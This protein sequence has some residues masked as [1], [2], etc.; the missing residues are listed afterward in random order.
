MYWRRL[1]EGLHTLFD[2]TEEAVQGALSNAASQSLESAYRT[3][4]AH[5]QTLQVHGYP[6]GFRFCNRSPDLPHLYEC[7]GSDGIE[8]IGLGFSSDSQEMA[9]IKS[10]SESLERYLWREKK[11]FEG[12]HVRTTRYDKL[13]GALNP[14]HLAGFSESQKKEPLLYWDTSKPLTWVESR[15]ITSNAATWVPLQLVSMAHGEAA[16]CGLIPEPLLRQNSTNGLA[17][18]TDFE[19]AVYRGLLELIER[20]AFV[21]SFF[22]HITAPTLDSRTVRDP[23]THALIE[24][25]SRY[26]FTCEFVNLPTDMPVYV[27]CAVIRNTLSHGPALSLGARAHHNAHIAVHEALLEALTLMSRTHRGNLREQ[28]LPAGSWSITDRLAFWSRPENA[29]RFDWFTK[30]P[31][32]PIPNTSK[33]GT[34]LRTLRR[35]LESKGYDATAVVLNP[36]QIEGLGLTSAYVICPQLQPIDLYTIPPY[37]GGKRLHEIPLLFGYTPHTDPPPYPHPFP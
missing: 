19:G 16:Q 17:T 22:N 11:T 3:A 20:D 2:R 24:E 21:I 5:A 14:E 6:L 9:F 7:V 8:E 34:S 1:T 15:P 32:I 36:P 18:Y 30:G 33:S 28:E 12:K 27:V 23:R 31:A 26:G 35:S 37:R 29:S 10:L 4:L 13:P 25:V